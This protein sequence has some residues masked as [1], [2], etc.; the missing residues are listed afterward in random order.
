VK[1]LAEVSLNGTS[2]GILWKEP[3]KVDI[4][5][6]L[7]PGT[8]QLEIKITNE[9]T[10]RQIGDKSTGRKVLASGGPATGGFGAPPTLVESGL[11]GPVAIFSMVRK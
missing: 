1:D 11:I 2:L 4:T 8:N 6:A 7:K 5:E 10:N 9:W 3:Y